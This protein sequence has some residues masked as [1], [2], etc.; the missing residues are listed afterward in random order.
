MHSLRD[1]HSVY[2]VMIWICAVISF[3]DEGEQPP[4]L[5][6]VQVEMC[7]QTVYVKQVYRQHRVYFAHGW[8]LVGIV[9]SFTFCNR[10]DQSTDL[11]DNNDSGLG[12]TVHS[13]AGPALEFDFGFDLDTSCLQHTRR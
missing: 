1:V 7:Y 6:D 5:D 10:S 12:P 8:V 4:H 11:A 13:D 2:G 9:N 3:L